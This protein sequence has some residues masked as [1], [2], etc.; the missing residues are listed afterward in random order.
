MRIRRTE[1]G[2][3]LASAGQWVPELSLKAAWGDWLLTGDALARVGVPL[4]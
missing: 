2:S 4:F 3:A 1:I